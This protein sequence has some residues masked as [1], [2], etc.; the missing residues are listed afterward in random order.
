MDRDE[1][2][3]SAVAM[4]GFYA[5]GATL[6]IASTMGILVSIV[7]LAEPPNGSLGARITAGIGL[8]TSLAGFWIGRRLSDDYRVL[9]GSKS[10]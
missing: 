2:W 8:V 7:F 5:F 3:V 10:R 9:P 4:W 6:L 1:S